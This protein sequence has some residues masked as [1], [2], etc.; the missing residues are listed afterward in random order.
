MFEY[1]VFNVTQ[2]RVCYNICDVIHS[3]KKYL[4][5]VNVPVVVA[6]S[7]QAEAV[8]AI[9]SCLETFLSARFKKGTRNHSNVKKNDLA[10]TYLDK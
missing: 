5:C 2:A 8:G 7:R 9:R 1:L 4:V 10:T 6:L 3:L